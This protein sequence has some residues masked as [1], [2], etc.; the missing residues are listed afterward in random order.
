MANSIVSQGSTAIM[1]LEG[2]VDIN[3]TGDLRD[4]MSAIGSGTQ[5]IS[6]QA[7]HVTYIDSSGIALLLL[8]KQTAEKFGAG[9]S[10]D[11]I[12]AE[13]VK[14]IQLAKLDAVLPVRAASTQSAPNQ[15]S[16]SGPADNQGDF[17]DIFD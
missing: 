14:V 11:S 12:S 16:G 15:Q 4:Q 5:Q 1:T 6:V 8:A 17:S 2:D 7:G 3:T 10:I 9:F 13:V